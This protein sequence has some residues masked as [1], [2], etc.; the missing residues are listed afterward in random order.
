[1][2]I[3]LLEAEENYLLEEVEAVLNERL[4][5]QWFPGFEPDLTREIPKSNKN[6]RGA[7]KRRAKDRAYGKN[8]GNKRRRQ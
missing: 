5:Q 1:M 3:S 6:S 2:A 8:T 7:Q 4:A